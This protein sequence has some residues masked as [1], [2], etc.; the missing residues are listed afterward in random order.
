V[1][2]SRFRS[3]ADFIA[4]KGKTGKIV[5]GRRSTKWFRGKAV[6][7]TVAAAAV[8]VVVSAAS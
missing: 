5:M 2:K 1:I 4:L 3:H 7:V 8:A 6:A